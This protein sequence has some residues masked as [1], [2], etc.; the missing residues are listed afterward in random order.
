MLDP[1][2]HLARDDKWYLGGGDGTLYAPTYPA[3]LDTPGYWDE[4]T[5]Y[6]YGFAP[7]FTV[8]V[9]DEAGREIPAR[10][11]SRRW[12]PADLTVTYR[13][14]SGI[15]ATEVRTV[16]PG[17]VFVSEW[18]FAAFEP[19]RVHLV[20]WTA[21]DGASVPMGEASW[22]NGA[23]CFP[24]VL[25]DR[26][27]QPLRVRAELACVGQAA[28]WAASRSEK[29]APQ[30]YW[31]Y[32][33]FVE[34]WRAGGLP[35]LVRDEGISLDG[36]FYAAVHRTMDIGYRGSSAVFAMRIVADDPALPVPDSPRS[37]RP[38]HGTIAGASRRRWHAWFERV[39]QLR[40]SDPYLETYYYYRWYGL[41]LNTTA[42]G[43]GNHRWPS[44][45][46][47]IGFFHQPISYSA[48][49]HARELRWLDDPSH[50]RGVLRT[51]FAHQKE[52]GSLHGRVYANHLTGTD[53]YHADWGGALVALDAAWPD[54]AF[55]SEI[56]PAMARFAEWMV[57]T[58]DADGTGMFDVVDQ[59][60]TGQEYMSRYQAVDA[61]ADRYGW[62]NRLR[63]KGIDVTVYAY[64]L[65]RTLERYAARVGGDAARWK[66][67][68]TRTRDAV[69]DEMWDPLGE[70]FSDVHPKT[71]TRTGV[72][73]AVCFYPYF[74]DIVDES[75]LRGL[76]QSLL[77]PKQFWTEFPV[78]SSSLDD[79]LFSAEAEWKGKRHVCPWN[80]RT[81]PMT[82]SHL[83]EALAAAS[84][85][86]V[87][88]HSLREQ[89]GQLIKRFV[90]MMFHDGDLRRPN[91]FE[92][93]NPFTGHASVYRGIDDYQHS[94]VADLILQ[95]AA[96]VRPNDHGI[97]VDPFPLG[98]EQL[99]LT[100]VRVR[101]RT[102]EVRI[103]GDKF[104]VIFG[105]DRIESTLGEAVEL[106]G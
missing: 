84:R 80:G 74:T 33:P 66:Q 102:L 89:T 15:T 59:Y 98:L 34:Q 16:H 22:T 67:L 43:H 27:Q 73:A 90:R 17:G 76:R 1:I 30:P 55:I 75:H 96:G 82:N 37:V 35:R 62:E 45:C 97:T 71:G 99:T 54:D 78:P 48:Q 19:A 24:R 39:P 85:I 32:T 26:R 9:L 70:L 7:L 104:T 105:G 4:A 8:T 21:Q 56:Y 23:V 94:W 91:C 83:V 12:T 14:E 47:G 103:V 46:E 87:H 69:R 93:Y 50:A 58:R 63:L 11:T 81:W 38:T 72:K 65:F 20:A 77:D 42:A 95:Y 88:S 31:R 13:L 68:A 51:F 101:G 64:V 2:E 18:R 28:S 44:M 41:H 106:E 61:D 53:Y 6:Q 25:S 92:H 3:W 86:G 36:L 60:E 79:P 57:R 10:A 29:S 5:V 49:C 40:C 52:D 100:G